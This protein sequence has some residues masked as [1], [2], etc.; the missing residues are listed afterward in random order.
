MCSSVDLRYVYVHVAT[1][2]TLYNCV[3]YYCTGI[4]AAFNTVFTSGPVMARCHDDV[5]LLRTGACFRITA[6]AKNKTASQ[7]LAINS[8]VT[9]AI[10]D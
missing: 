3:Y 10:R 6:A 7:R 5:Q 4:G 8:M 1:C 9:R 2:S